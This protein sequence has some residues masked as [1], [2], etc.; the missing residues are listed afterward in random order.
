[1]ELLPLYEPAVCWIAISVV[2]VSLVSLSSMFN[3]YVASF[4]HSSS[5]LA[6]GTSADWTVRHG[7]ALALAEATSTS[8]PAME[9]VGLRGEVVASALSHSQSDR[10][11][12]MGHDH[13]VMKA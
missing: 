5:P 2:L 13:Y 6:G 12:P 3:F 8:G 9:E 11:S 7:C 4:D 10:V 1:M